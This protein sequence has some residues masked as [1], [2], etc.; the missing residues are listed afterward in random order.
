[1][2]LK[3]QVWLSAIACLFCLAG[4][5]LCSGVD[6]YE[7][8]RV[9]T[10]HCA[11]CCVLKAAELSRGSSSGP[12][13]TGICTL[14]CHSGLLQPRCWSRSGTPAGN[15]TTEVN[16]S[17][18]SLTL[19]VDAFKLVFP[20]VTV[21]FIGQFCDII[22]NILDVC[23]FL[24]CDSGNNNKENNLIKHTPS[25]TLTHV[26]TAVSLC[27]TDNITNMFQVASVE[28]EYHLFHRGPAH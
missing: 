26:S 20:L 17:C 7:V 9:G 16:A 27:A 6:L 28:M 22:D 12:T 14:R 3:R 2:C 11:D 8:V 13:Q 23:V 15:H 21:D 18:A 10:H 19:I 4:L 5:Y 25:V 1:M 24:C